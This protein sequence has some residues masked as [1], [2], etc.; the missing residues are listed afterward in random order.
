MKDSACQVL[1]TDADDV[2]QP[3]PEHPVQ[4]C[5]AIFFKHLFVQN[6]FPS[7]I[8]KKCF[9]LGVKARVGRESGNKPFFLRPKTP[10]HGDKLNTVQ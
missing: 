9:E 5:K 1:S 3:V 10:G 4:S 2:L 7:K 8:L 6:D